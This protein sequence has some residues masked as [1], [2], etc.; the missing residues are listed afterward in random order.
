MSKAKDV[1]LILQELKEKK[2]PY[3]KVIEIAKLPEDIRI[4]VMKNCQEIFEMKLADR[5]K[6]SW[7]YG[8]R[9]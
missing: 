4:D 3:E 9:F 2:S 1:E 6:F 7:K 5:R 8:T